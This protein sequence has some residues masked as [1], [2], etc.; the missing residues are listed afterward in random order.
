MF[1][2]VQEDVFRERNYPELINS[3]DRMGLDYEI[4]K[5]KPFVEELEFKTDRKDVFVFGSVKLARLAQGY[6]WSPGSEL[7]PNHRANMQKLL[8][9]L[10]DHYG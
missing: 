6:G 4:I 5:V 2:L 3:M 8:E 1:Y 7:G 9:N 10:E